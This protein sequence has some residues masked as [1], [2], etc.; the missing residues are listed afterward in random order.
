MSEEITKEM[1]YSYFANELT[2]MQKRR[3]DE[4]AKQE[5]NREL[6]YECLAQWETQ[7]IQYHSDIESALRRHQRRQEAVIHSTHEKDNQSKGLSRGTV[8]RLVA[9]AAILLIMALAGYFSKDEIL[10]QTISTINGQTK[11]VSLSDGTR[12]ILNS[13]SAITVPRFGFGEKTRE[14]FLKG[15]ANFSVT[16]LPNKQKFVV[17]TVDGADIVVLGT[18]F[19]VYSRAHKFKVALAKGKIQLNYKEETKQ[20]ELVMK[21]GDLVTINSKEGKAVLEKTEHPQ[22][23]SDAKDNRYVFE[24]TAL[25][26]VCA[27][28]KKDFNIEIEIEDPEISTWAVSGSFKASNA[29]ELLEA[30]AE[31]SGMVYEE[32]DKRIIIHSINK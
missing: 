13:N 28:L 32:K 26:D 23:F 7:N 15:E 1:L 31:T 11:S 19:T 10:N 16:H 6:F 30:L 21:P 2:T 18:E 29:Q 24:H 9:A 22:K 8:S 25:A 20:K 3:I 4:W 12:V 27:V 5:E 14:V 17:K